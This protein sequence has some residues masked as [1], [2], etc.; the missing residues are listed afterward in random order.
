MAMERATDIPT[1]PRLVREHRTLGGLIGLY[2]MDKHGGGADLCPACRELVD[3][4][5]AR[6]ARCPFGRRKP[7]CS[8]C[9]IHCYQSAMRERIR[10]VMRVAGRRLLLARPLLAL[11]HLLDALRPCPD[12][13]PLK[14]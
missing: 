4:A 7:T 5:R 9:P 14:R 2:C 3:Y 6:L 13:R 10:D 11:G 1:S 8:R 12:R